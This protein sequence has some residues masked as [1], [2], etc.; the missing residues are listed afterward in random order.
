MK[1]TRASSNNRQHHTDD[2]SAPNAMLDLYRRQWHSAFTN[3]FIGFGLYD[4]DRRIIDGNQALERLVGRSIDELRASPMP[5]AT[6]PSDLEA[7]LASFR[8]VAVGHQ[9]QGNYT[10]RYVHRDGTVIWCHVQLGL[11]R[12]SREKPYR[13]VMLAVDVTAQVRAEQALRAQVLGLSGMELTILPLLARPDLNSYPQIGA[14]L[15][16]SGETVRKHAQHLAEKL[17]L[18]TA[19]RSEIVRAAREQGLLDLIPHDLLDEAG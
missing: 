19:A 16:R 18:P 15:S 1:R 14:R 4:L 17:G 12:D 2:Q 13:I 7:N 9:E 3:A 6:H 10:K 11:I 8:A 5:I